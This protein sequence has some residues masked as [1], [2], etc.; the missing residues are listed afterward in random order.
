ME[1]DDRIEGLV[2]LLPRIEV[3]FEN[4]TNLE[5]EPVVALFPILAKQ[6]S[7]AIPRREILN[8]ITKDPTRDVKVNC[9]LVSVKP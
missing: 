2:V 7:T 8:A 9:F 6:S 3:E 5:P 1:L 4:L